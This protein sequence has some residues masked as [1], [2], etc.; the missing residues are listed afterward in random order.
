MSDQNENH[1][2][3]LTDIGRLTPEIKSFLNETR[4]KLKGHERR[5]FMA[6][7]VSILGYG[8]QIKAE[9][10]LGWDRKTIIKGTKELKSDIICFD[11]F[12]D[13]RFSKKRF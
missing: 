5:Q 7:V 2:N 10:E 12:S 1:I 3:N 8:G 4:N 9:R 11:N 6:R 13:H